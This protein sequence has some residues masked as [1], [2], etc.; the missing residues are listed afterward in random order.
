[1]TKII[2]GLGNPGKSYALTRHNVGFMVVDRL[3]AQLNIPVTSIRFKGLFGEGI[4]RGEKILLL[5]PQTYMNLSGES[6]REM[7]DWYKLDTDDVLLIYDDLDLPVG[8]LR[9]RLK[10][11]A[12]GHN[13][14]KSI[15]YHTETDALKRIKI[16]INRPP[17]G[18]SVSDYVLSKFTASEAV[19][20]DLVLN[21]A[22]DAIIAW[23]DEP[24]TNVMNRFN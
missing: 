17:A 8:Q 23:L 22:V 24:F 14:V 1:M 16:G 2:I 18:W 15:L 6:V 7:L 11:S 12:G 5:K 9:L 20:I 19:D 21:R 13:G 10:G 4:V 3:S